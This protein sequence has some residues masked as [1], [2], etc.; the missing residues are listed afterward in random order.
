MAE[1]AP[2]PL[3]L[4]IA[5]MVAKYNGHHEATS[6]MMH[7]MLREIAR[8]QAKLIEE[9]VVAAG[10]DTHLWQ[11]IDYRALPEDEFFIVWSPDH[12]KIPLTVKREIF[13]YGSKE[14]TPKHLSMR[15]FTH[16]RPIMPLPRV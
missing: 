1:Y 5:E 8:D 15:H 4:L 11:A 9:A 13:V 7:D 12:P 10:Y 6:P 16:W 2:S 14:G 3:A